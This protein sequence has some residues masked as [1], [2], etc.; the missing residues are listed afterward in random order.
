LIAIFNF[1]FLVLKIYFIFK[2]E[3]REEK[4]QREARI[5]LEPIA[6]AFSGKAF[7]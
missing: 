5:P 1:S 7:A 2:K 3:R 4:L 6:W